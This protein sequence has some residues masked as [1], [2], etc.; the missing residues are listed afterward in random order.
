MR[1][2]MA[3]MWNRMRSSLMGRG[4]DRLVEDSDGAGT[5]DESAPSRSLSTDYTELMGGSV[6]C[7]SCKGTGR[8]PKEMEETLVA[9]IPVNDD[10]LKPK[11][12]WRWVVVVVLACVLIAAGVIYM[13]VP[14]AVELHS[15]RRS[16]DKV[17]VFRTQE[18]PPQLEFWFMNY[19]NISNANYYAVQVLN[20][21]AS[22]VSKFQPWSKE[23][24]GSGGNGSTIS[25]SPLND[26]RMTALSFNNT[27]CTASF[28]RLTS[29]YVNMQFDVVVT[30]MYF[31]HREQ[32]S[33][34]TV[35]QKAAMAEDFE[36][37]YTDLKEQESEDSVLTSEQQLDRLLRPGSTYLNLNPFEVLQIS[38][39]T[40][41]EQA[42]K[43]Y[44]KLSLLIH[45]DKNPDDRERA[46]K[47][48]DIVKKAVA[49]M[50]DPVALAKAKDCYKEAEARLAIMLSEKRR[51]AKKEGGEGVIDEDEPKAYRKALWVIVTKVF[52]DRE[53]KRKMLEERANDEKRRNA[54]AALEAA[55]KRKLAEEFAKNYE[56]SRDERRG[57]WRNFQAKKARKE[58]KGQTMKGSS[59]KPP[60]LKP[61]TK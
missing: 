48:F 41:L 28:S 6:P 19:V 51:K 53:K 5:S 42:K 35:Q 29:L 59:F 22:V 10:R 60:K 13:L 46:D 57:A 47:A 20:T 7:P 11:H 14:R 54:E 38:P 21:T 4:H 26:G 16:I 17:N 56:E 44:K 18:K 50:E 2:A 12:T 15:D 30:L 8:I 52:A 55:E 32:I 1:G 43:K 37:F 9:L 33:L 25:V 39:D 49:V 58:E 61:Q 24:I 36:R 23:N 27:Y 45:P 3:N 31:N 34:S 40:D